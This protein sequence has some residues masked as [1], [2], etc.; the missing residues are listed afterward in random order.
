MKITEQQVQTFASNLCRA[1]S[2][3]DLTKPANI[4]AT[5]LFRQVHHALKQT[6][7]AV[8]GPSMNVGPNDKFTIRGDYNS[9]EYV[10]EIIVENIRLRRFADDQY[11]T[12]FMC[13]K[14]GHARTGRQCLHCENSKLRAALE[15]IANAEPCSFVQTAREAL[16]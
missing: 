12:C 14:C 6:L 10:Q 3:Q 15:R 7:E 4:F 11:R 8:H 16:R 1:L 2:E 9:L 13:P 5:P